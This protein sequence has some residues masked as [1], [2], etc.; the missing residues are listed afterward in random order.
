MQNNQQN[1]FYPQVTPI[2]I[3]YPQ[4]EIQ[5]QPLL[6]KQSPT[7]QYPNIQGYQ[8]QL[9]QQ[10]IQQQNFVNYQQQGPVLY[11][12]QQ[13]PVQQPQINVEAKPLN[14]GA[15]LQPR[16]PVGTLNKSTGRLTFHS[17]L[18]FYSIFLFAGIVTT[19]ITFS[20]VMMISMSTNHFSSWSLLLFLIPTA[21]FFFSIFF[22]RYKVEFDDSRKEMI[23]SSNLVILPC[24][25]RRSEVIP[26]DR[27]QDIYC[28]FFGGYKSNVICL[29]TRNEKYSLLSN[30]NNWTGNGFNIFY[31]QAIAQQMRE[32]LDAIVKV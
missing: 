2:N 30:A 31:N 25:L 6:Q 4:E 7:Q 27:I 12:S 29:T 3:H 8:P 28:E 15:V 32:H 26:Y 20:Q 16:E 19:M 18:L 24:C 23:I 1:N 17:G 11:Q 9:Y 14:F 13:Q 10:P 21:F 5:K 22:K